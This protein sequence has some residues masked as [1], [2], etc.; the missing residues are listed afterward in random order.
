MLTGYFRRTI[1]VVV[2]I[3]FNVSITR[4]RVRNFDVSA[5]HVCDPETASLLSLGEKPL[6]RPK[7]RR[8]A[9]AEKGGPE[10]R[11]QNV[12]CDPDRMPARTRAPPDP[13]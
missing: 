8:V 6:Q 10:C 3:A 13:R 7:E 2:R 11:K 1:I 9:V 5:G 4:E 12:R